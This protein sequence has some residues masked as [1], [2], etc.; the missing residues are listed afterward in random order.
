MDPITVIALGWLVTNYLYQK[1]QQKDPD[2]AKEIQRPTVTE[3][4]AIPIYFGVTRVRK[5]V[6][7]WT[8]FPEVAREPYGVE[9]TFQYFLPLFYVIGSGYEN[10]L[11]LIS[12]MYVGDR[13]MRSAENVEPFPQVPPSVDPRDFFN[14]SGNASTVANDPDNDA[15]FSYVKESFGYDYAVTPD[16][17]KTWVYGPAEYLNGKATQKL[18]DDVASST[19]YTHVGR[20]MLDNGVDY[21]DIPGFRGVQSVFLGNTSADGLGSQWSV[22]LSPQIGSYSFE[23]AAFFLAGNYNGVG[24]G[25]WEFFLTATNPAYALFELLTGKRGKCGIPTQKIDIDSFERAAKT[26]YDEGLGFN[27]SYEGVRAEEAVAEM[28]RYMAAS[29]DENPKTGLIRLKLIR[30]DYDPNDIPLIYVGN[31]SELKNVSLSSRTGTTNKVT[32]VYQNKGNSYQDSTV[33]A[34]N[35]AIMLN[36]EN[37]AVELRYPCCTDPDA[38]K[39]VAERELSARSRPIWRLNATV[40][41][42]FY[43]AMAGDAIR[44]TWAPYGLADTVFRVVGSPQRG[45]IDDDSI[46]LDLIQDFYFVHKKSVNTG[47]TVGPF[48]DVNEILEF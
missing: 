47:G 41:R 27:R 32:V 45:T 33:E 40:D 28:L 13:A 7:A 30:A 16:D 12:R 35:H 42:T 24:L 38:A 39:V 19:Y 8:G 20:A 3:G 36:T 37:R 21:R 17:Q 1:S 4:D 31:C 6:L 46:K 43:R 9:G 10:G 5:P 44:V 25:A 29:L 22:G 14:S 18:V 48:P 23:M 15:T 11:N 34:M 2:P 26:L